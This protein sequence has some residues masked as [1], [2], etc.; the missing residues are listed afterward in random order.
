MNYVYEFLYADFPTYDEIIKEV[1]EVMEESFDS[2][3]TVESMLYS[4]QRRVDKPAKV[5]LDMSGFVYYKHG[6][7][8]ICGEHPDGSIGVVEVKLDYSY[9]LIAENSDLHL[10]NTKQAYY[11]MYLVLHPEMFSSDKLKQV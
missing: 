5:F 1:E 11:F 2:S 10:I 6:D 3:D 4:I 7:S 9:F 8:C